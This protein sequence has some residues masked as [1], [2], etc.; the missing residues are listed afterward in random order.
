MQS[1]QAVSADAH[2]LMQLFKAPASASLRGCPSLLLSIPTLQST[3]WLA[4]SLTSQALS[5]PCS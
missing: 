2:R 1:T 5:V 3:S 4:G